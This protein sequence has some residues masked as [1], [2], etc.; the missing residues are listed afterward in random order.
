MPE[1]VA[2]R[3]SHRGGLSTLEVN[4]SRF[5]AAGSNRYQSPNYDQA[6]DKVDITLETGVTSIEID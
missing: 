5:P 3:I 2:A 1:N 6:K 4:E